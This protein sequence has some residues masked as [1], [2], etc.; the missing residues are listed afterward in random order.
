MTL[1]VGK[2]YSVT[3]IIELGK[4]L[5]HSNLASILFEHSQVKLVYNNDEFINNFIYNNKEVGFMDYYK[6]K[7]IP[8]PHQHLLSCSNPDDEK[9][10][11]TLE[12]SYEKENNNNNTETEKELVDIITE[13]QIPLQNSINFIET[14]V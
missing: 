12:D 6:L 5:F 3:E 14:S 2:K 1:E 7:S 4:T 9:L 13:G 8:Q 10:Q 11:D